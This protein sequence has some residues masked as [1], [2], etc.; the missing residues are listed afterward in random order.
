M[1]SSK[2]TTLLDGPFKTPSEA[3]RFEQKLLE[4]HGRSKEVIGTFQDYVLAILKEDGQ[5]EVNLT[6]VLRDRGTRN[7]YRK[8]LDLRLFGPSPPD[9]PFDMVRRDRRG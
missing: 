7:L 5:S 8:Y 9:L 2:P 3:T 6:N 1:S 4:M